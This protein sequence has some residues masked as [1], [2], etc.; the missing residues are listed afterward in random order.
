MYNDLGLTFVWKHSILTGSNKK[1]VEKAVS[2]LS[3]VG[4]N[5]VAT[6]GKE[7]LKFQ[8]GQVIIIE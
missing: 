7:M 5:F 6:S 2:D 1:N 8:D 3:K 4:R